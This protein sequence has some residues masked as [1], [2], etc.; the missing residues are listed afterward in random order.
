M[1]QYIIKYT[2]A[3]GD[4]CSVWVV[5]DTREDAK[6]QACASYWDIKDIVMVTEM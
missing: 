1:K 3:S 2:T 6:R 5:A 4:L